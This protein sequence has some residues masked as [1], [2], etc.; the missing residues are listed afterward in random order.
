MQTLVC[1]T[2]R[3]RHVDLT[4]SADVRTLDAFHQKSLRQLL[5]IRRYDRVWNDEVLQRTGLTSLSHLLSRRRVSVFEHVPRLD[6][7]TPANMALQLRINV[8]LNRPRDRTW[9]RSPGR[10]RNKW[11]D[12]LR[13]DSTVR[14][15]SSGDVCRPWTWWCNDATTLT[16]YAT[17]MMMMMMERRTAS[18]GVGP[19]FCVKIGARVARLDCR[20][21]EEPKRENSRDKGVRRVAHAQKRNPLSDLDKVSK[22][23][24]QLVEGFLVGGGQIFPFSS[25]SS[26][27]VQHCSSTVWVC[28]ILSVAYLS[29]LLHWSF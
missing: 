26:S 20:R 3:R 14:L 21:L 1:V 11:L 9:R 17:M 18:F 29:D 12:Q 22:F 16:G 28:D 23:W 27:P 8:S 25:L 5:G 15:E 10:P 19:L 7:D 2:I 24:W 4:I 13:N 6:D